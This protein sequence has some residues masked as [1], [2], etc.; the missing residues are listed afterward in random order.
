MSSGR[1][2][3]TEL[4]D[5]LDRLP[6]AIE[7]AAARTKLLAPKR[8]SSGSVRR[9]DLAAP[10]DADARHATLRATI[11]WSHELLTA[12]EQTL[13]ARLSVFAAGCTLES[14]ELV[15]DAGLAGL[16]SL[17]DKSL[18]RRRDGALGEDRFWLLATIR[19]YAAERLAEKSERDELHRRHAVRMLQIARSA[20]LSPETALGVEPQRHDLVLAEREDVRAAL[21]WAVGN[22]VRLGL[23]L[24]MVL[25]NFWAAHNPEEGARRLDQLLE[26]AG[27]LPPELEA[28]ALRLQG[29]HAARSG[30]RELGIRRYEE[31]LAAYRALGD[32]HGTAIVLGRIAANVVG[33]GDVARG[34]AL[35][36]E[37]LE[38]ARSLELGWVEATS[39]GVLG[40][41]HRADG[42][43][44]EAWEIARRSVELAAQSGFRWWQ[45]G[46]LT[47]VMELGL[48]LGRL[49][50]AEQA[51]REALRLATTMEDRR[52]TLWALTGLAVIEHERGNLERSGRVWGA[53]AEEDERA[54]V[55]L[56]AS[57][58]SRGRWRRRWTRSFGRH[59]AGSRRRARGG[60]RAR[61]GRGVA[62][63]TP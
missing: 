33:Q 14:A 53:V 63:D 34:R 3:S 35:A 36:Q 39:V 46:Q 24:V 51:G 2:R 5:R 19:E 29:N 40:Y 7:L 54:P 12:E 26:R 11:A 49:E 15:C 60:R 61:P 31:S 45:A 55:P 6:L 23:E 50:E 17:L 48:E 22:D 21:D 56:K 58:T 32:E 13:F 10:R 38:L 16:E 18:L 43:L 57:A 44:E 62:P 37:A 8:C 9:L 28:R 52:Y 47:E 59:G 41:A 30:A 4:C 1:L 42:E 25:E 20:H 27:Q